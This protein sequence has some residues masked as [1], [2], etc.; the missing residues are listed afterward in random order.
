[1]ASRLARHVVLIMT[2]TQR[3]DML[4]CYGNL[5]MKTPCLDALAAGGLRFD[6]AYTCQPVCGPARSALFTGA[7]PHSNGSWANCMPLGANVKTVGQRLRDH[8]IH[9]ACIGK[10]HLDGGD[11]FGLGRCPDGWDP[12]YWY[13][14]RNYLEELTPAERLRSR[15]TETNRDPGLTAAF[16]FGHRCSQRALDFLQKHHAE[17]FFLVVSYDEP[18]GPCLCP[19]PYSEMYRDYE[20]PKSRNIWDTLADKPEH[21]R[22]W[23]GKSL[24]QDKDALRI[25]PADYLGCN[26]FVDSEIGRVLEALARYAPDALVLYTSDHGD[27]LGAHSLG[28]KGPAMYE[29]ITRVPF[30]VRW[31]GRTPERAA[32]G[33]PVSHIDVVPT[34]LDAFGLPQPKSLEGRSM[35]PTFGAP[36][37]KAGDTVFMEFGRY[38]TDHDGFGGFQPIRAACDGRCKLVL[39]LLAGDELYDLQADPQELA[40]LIAAAE[41]AAVRNA[42]HDRILEWMNR[43]RDPFRGYYW[44]RR[45]WRTDARPATW[46]YTLMT[47]QRENEEY[48]P[49]QLDY[50]TGL[51]MQ[52]AVRP[53]G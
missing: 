49:R 52:K 10:W 46:D 30:I 1:M 19:R 17:D 27:A 53:K 38:E 33:H 14:M 6:H 35:L 7:W 16:T 28:N 50:N 21:Q 20:W 29:E 12:A 39:N 25:R 3:A 48:E 42:L 13:D 22:V 51:E 5:E 11:Y 9:T 34:I 24:Q 4:G 45:P 18:H 40:N 43:T 32:C 8:G 37:L 2:D 23:A 31:P 15:R 26:S 36:E 41:Y 47:R 44:E